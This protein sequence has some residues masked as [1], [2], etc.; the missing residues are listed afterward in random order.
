MKLNNMFTLKRKL[1][2]N[3]IITPFPHKNNR[4]IKKS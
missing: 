2:T 3:F 1:Y 4:P